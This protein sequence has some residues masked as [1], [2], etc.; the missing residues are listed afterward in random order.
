MMTRADIVAVLLA[1]A[2][3]PVLYVNYWGD[4]TQGQAVRVLTAEGHETTVPIHNDRTLELAGPLGTSTLEIRDGKVRFVSSPCS[5][6]LCIRSGW[7]SHGGEFAACL[8]NQISLVVLGAK[9]RFD[10]INF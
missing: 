9:Q 7:L 1:A 5:N 10:A 4:G 8:P 6:K 2:M 3:L